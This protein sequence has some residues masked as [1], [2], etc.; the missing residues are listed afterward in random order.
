MSAFVVQGQNVFLVEHF[1][2]PADSLLQNNGWFAHSAGGTNPIKVTNGGLSLTNTAYLGSGIGNAAAVNNTGSDENRPFTSYVD[3]GNVYVSFL[4]KVNGPVTSGNTGFF[5][6]LGEYSNTTT[7]VFTSINTG[8]RARTFITTGTDASKFRLGLSFNATTITN[9]IGV[10]AS[11]DLD[12]GVTY[13]VVVK[14]QFVPGASND[15]VSLYVFPDGASIANEPAT[16]TIG[17]LVGTQ[18]DMSI[19]QAVILRQYNANQNITVDGIIAQDTWNLQ[20]ASLVGPTLISPPN[21]TFLDVTG[22]VST[23]A[24]IFWTSVQNASAPVTYTWELASAVAG[25]FNTPLL[26]IPSNLVGTDTSLTLGYGQIDAALASLSVNVG[27]TVFGI[28]RVRAITGTDTVFSNTFNINIRRG[29]VGAPI[30]SFN[31]LTPPNNTILPISGSG[32]QTATIRW[33]AASGGTQP[34]TYEWLAIAPGGSFATPVVAIPSGNNGSDTSLVLPYSAI[35]AL[36]GSLNFTIGDSVFL[37]WTVRATSGTQTNLATQTWR[38]TLFYGVVT[39]DTITAFSLLTP[40]NNTILPIS[41]LGTQTATINWRAASAGAQPI[42]YE[43]LAI[44]PGGSFATPVVAIP[45]GNNGSDTS[46]VL[47]YSA[48]SS[49]LGS[50]NFTI[51]DSV[52][53]DWTVRA[54]SGTQ[55]R[56]A[57]QTRRITLFFGV[58]T[59]DT[60]TAFNLLAPP[61]NTILPITGLGSQTATI[62]WRAAAGGTQPI[63]YEW[64]A[65]APGGTFTAPV[66]AIPSGNS[67]A[68]TSLTLTYTAIDALLASLNFTVGDSIFLDWTVRATSGTSSRLAS[69]TWRI[70][71]FYGGLF[72]DTL[73]GFSLLTP[74]NN[75]NLTIEGDPTQTASITWEPSTASISTGSPNYTWLLDVPT[76]DFSA[77]VLSISS[78]TNPNLTLPFGAIADSLAAKGVPVGGSFVGKWTVRATLGPLNRFATA[79]FNLTLNRGIMTS[80]SQNELSNSV[81]VF[82]NPTANVVNIKLPNNLNGTAYVSLVNIIGQE[83]QKLVVNDINGGTINLDVASQP[84]G[85]YFVKININNQVAL[86]RLVIQK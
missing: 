24:N 32:T 66:V 54:T 45:S 39:S 52:F 81:E 34:I 62:Q 8:F 64:L 1:N 35:S 63:T 56:L 36:L 86:K 4:M 78:G 20:P 33:N 59:S 43:W 61:N 17:P 26:S 82:P 68:D 44:A 65:I 14:Y 30:S 10:D 21:N 40:P 3:S 16:P 67:G 41:G 53:L 15:S 58:V 2:Y 48:I 76:G 7:P 80:A 60:I 51:G 85:V 42:T 55:T 50:L 5:F 75:T 79:P 37:D 18:A 83:V 72:A 46:L 77:P 19:A 31:L 69:Q 29:S 57:S 6:H 22:P 13:L 25:N 27:D 28:W 70:T 12:T 73:S 38:I 47:P 49:L 11:S 74:P 23:L 71:L 9:T 84:N